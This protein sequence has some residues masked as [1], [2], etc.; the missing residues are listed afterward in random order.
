MIELKRLARVCV[1]AL[2]VCMCMLSI[3]G[4]AEPGGVQK[5]AEGVYVWQGQPA[6]GAIA[7]CLWVVFKDYVVVVDANYP[8]GAEEILPQ[9]RKTTNKPIRY[10]L[11]THHHGD[12]SFGNS[13]FTKEGAIIVSSEATDSE[14]R[15]KN[16]ENWTKWNNPAHSLAGFHE[17]FAGITFSDRL[18]LDDG[19]QR[20]EMIRLGP[21]H[22]K[23]D[24]V[25]YL[26]KLGIVA[27]GDLCVTWALGNNFGDMGGSY[28]G[29]LGALDQMMG[30]KLTTVVPGHGA[31]GG[32]EILK[33]QRE[34]MTGLLAQVTAGKQAGKSAEQL[35]SDIDFDKYGF[36]ASDQPAR[37]GQVRAMYRHVSA[38]LP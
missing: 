31:V 11:N 17:E 29:W 26:P 28:A 5:L 2:T 30:W 19:T 35:V 4:H 32:P 1:I 9:I 33:A 24:S 13:V 3:A 18:V 16:P 34:Y 36:I 8:W 37:I 15:S 12:H 14:A 38:G 7:N 23:G 25:A 27:T 20:L 21:A 22:T 6:T 10:V